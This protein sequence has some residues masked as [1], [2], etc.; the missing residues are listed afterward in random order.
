MKKLLI[1]TLLFGCTLGATLDPLFQA[2]DNPAIASVV[3]STRQQLQKG[4]TKPEYENVKAN[5][6][7]NADIRRLIEQYKLDTSYESYLMYKQ[8]GLLNDL[9]SIENIKAK[10]KEATSQL[11]G[12]PMRNDSRKELRRSLMKSLTE[13]TPKQ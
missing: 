10:V 5:L 1:S 2:L 11:D 13:K 12:A 4:L 7:K 6:L 3:E 9:G 8:M